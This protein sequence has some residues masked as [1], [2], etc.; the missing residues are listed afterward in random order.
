MGD[1]P[2]VHRFEEEVES[3]REHGAEN[4]SEPVLL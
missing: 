3:R 1:L 2:V 4:G